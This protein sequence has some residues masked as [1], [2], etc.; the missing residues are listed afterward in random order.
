MDRINC[1]DG[2]FHK[3]SETQACKL[4]KTWKDLESFFMKVF[5]FL[6]EYLIKS[7]SIYSGVDEKIL[8]QN[9]L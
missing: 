5:M 6:N 2:R 7:F 3:E 4:P 1:V 8:E 9:L